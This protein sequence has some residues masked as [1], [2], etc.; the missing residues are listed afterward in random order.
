MDVAPFAAHLFQF[1][2]SA[3]E[4]GA[5]GVIFSRLCQKLVIVDLQCPLWQSTRTETFLNSISII[6]KN[7]FG[8]KERFATSALSKK[9]FSLTCHDPSGFFPEPMDSLAT[10]IHM[11]TVKLLWGH[12]QIKPATLSEKRPLLILFCLYLT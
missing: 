11:P 9:A 3:T 10:L 5:V 2:R 12:L 8:S 7:L 6:V 4:G 1:A